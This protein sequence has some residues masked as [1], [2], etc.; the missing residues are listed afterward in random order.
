MSCYKNNEKQTFI[1]KGNL[2]FDK[3]YKG[4]NLIYNKEPWYKSDESG[5]RYGLMNKSTVIV[6][7]G[8]YNN[9]FMYIPGDGYYS[10]VNN[11]SWYNYMSSEIT[12][13]NGANFLDVNTVYI[14]F[15]NGSLYTLYQNRAT[16]RLSGGW[17][18]S[19]GTG[20]KTY[21]GIYAVKN[22]EIYKI[23]FNTG[24]NPTVNTVTK[25]MDFNSNVILSK[26]LASNYIIIDGDLYSGTKSSSLTLINSGGWTAVTDNFGIK[27]GAIYLLRDNLGRMVLVDDSKNWIDVTFDNSD[28]YFISDKSKLGRVNA[29]GVIYGGPDDKWVTEPFKNIGITGRW[30]SFSDTGGGLVIRNG[31]LY[32]IKNRTL[33]IIDNT[34]YYTKCFGRCGSS[35]LSAAI[36]SGNRIID[37][38]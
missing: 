29:N 36:S 25:I 23:V 11:K 20:G 2:I 28:H 4:S 21:L 13:L 33:D 32:N 8:I 22:K 14:A 26:N 6:D 38:S 30:E 15:K 37:N 12:S 7:Q 27:N 35:T 1:G 18:K 31:A 34:R 9:G 24:S 10:I 19:F 16:E 5:Y 17:V 3:I